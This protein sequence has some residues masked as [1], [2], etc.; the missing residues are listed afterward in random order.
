MKGRVQRYLF[1][2]SRALGVMEQ[3]S[4]GKTQCFSCFSEIDID[5][6]FMFKSRLPSLKNQYSSTP[7]LHYS[8]YLY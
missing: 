2:L 6:A 5:V 7:I 3:W 8:D 4:N 1:C